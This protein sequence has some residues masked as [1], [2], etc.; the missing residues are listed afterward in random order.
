[1]DYCAQ[2]V[3]ATLG[4]ALASED[5]GRLDWTSR[6]GNSM[7]LGLAKGRLDGAGVPLYPGSGQLLDDESPGGFRF[8]SVAV[9]TRTREFQ[10]V[11]A[12]GHGIAGSGE[13]DD[14]ALRRC[15]KG[16]YLSWRQRSSSCNSWICRSAASRLAMGWLVAGS[17]HSGWPRSQRAWGPRTSLYPCRTAVLDIPYV[18][19]YKL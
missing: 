2:D 17:R 7:R 6:R 3:W 8:H 1:M 9:L 12:G 14:C 10:K 4:L 19:W 11:P 18:R 16:R 5:A 15:S 13:H